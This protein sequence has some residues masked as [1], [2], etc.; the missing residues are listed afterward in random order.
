MSAHEQIPTSQ[1]VLVLAQTYYYPA[2]N[3]YLHYQKLC[4]D[5]VPDPSYNTFLNMT[6]ID[7][8]RAMQLKPCLQ[9]YLVGIGKLVLQ[10]IQIHKFA[11][12][13]VTLYTKR[14]KS[15]FHEARVLHKNIHN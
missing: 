8:G 1:R 2:V 6:Y 13:G 7:G 15:D 11:Y 10:L 3:R 5:Y 9:R 4:M 14:W 12:L